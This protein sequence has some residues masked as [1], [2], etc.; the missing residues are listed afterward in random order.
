[1]AI[2]NGR[3]SVDMFEQEC[4][5]ILV[6]AVGVTKVEEVELRSIVCEPC[7]L[8]SS[9]LPLSND[10]AFLFTPRIDRLLLVAM[11]QLLLRLHRIG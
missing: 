7:S 6:L 5:M 9:E 10:P 1:M 8:L 4:L 3:I 11:F 2:L